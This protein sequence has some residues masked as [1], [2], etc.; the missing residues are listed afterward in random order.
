MKKRVLGILAAFFAGFVALTSCQDEKPFSVYQI[1]VIY[2]TLN[3]LLSQEQ[4]DALPP[5]EKDMCKVAIY[6][7]QWFFKNNFIRNGSGG[8]PILIEG[9][10]EAENDRQ[11][12]AI[13]DNNLSELQKKQFDEIIRE[14]QLTNGTNG[15]PELTV[16]TT[17]S[18][19]FSYVMKKGSNAQTTIRSTSFTVN[20][21]PLDTP[22]EPQ[23]PEL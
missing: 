20:Y 2:P 7:N 16:T 18:L 19:V 4:I 10:D 21:E 5:T 23:E 1:G 17:G 8:N 15:E 22:S 6:L 11:A 14:A 12:I 9:A 3:D 13:Y